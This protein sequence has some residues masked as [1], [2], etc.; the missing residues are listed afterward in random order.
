MAMA[1]ERT[2]KRHVREKAI[3]DHLAENV[4]NPKRS[5]EKLASKI[6]PQ[7]PAC[8]LRIRSA[9]NWILVKVAFPRFDERNPGSIP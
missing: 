6:P 4:Y 2:L 7:L 5:A 9:R 3:V 1:P 8:R